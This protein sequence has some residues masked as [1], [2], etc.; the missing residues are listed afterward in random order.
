MGAMLGADEGPLAYATGQ[1]QMHCSRKG[2]G[3]R[4]AA[5]AKVICTAAKAKQA[6]VL[7]CSEQSQMHTRAA[8][9]R[10][11]KPIRITS[12][13]PWGTDAQCVIPLHG[14]AML[15]CMRRNLTCMS[16]VFFMQNSSHLNKSL[17]LAGDWAR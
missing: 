9:A 14:M 13:T 16:K 12:T 10:H 11:A 15:C 1:E 5:R 6:A 4:L 2:H 3:Q 8:C 17:I 7:S